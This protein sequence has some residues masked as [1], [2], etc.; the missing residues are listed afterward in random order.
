MTNFNLELDFYGNGNLNEIFHP[1]LPFSFFK[2][3]IYL[4]S[5]SNNANEWTFTA[6]VKALRP[7]FYM[8]YQGPNGSGTSYGLAYINAGTRDGD[9]FYNVTI[10]YRR[11]KIMTDPR[12]GYVTWNGQGKELVTNAYLVVGDMRG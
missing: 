7:F 10:T 9:G 5:S 2:E 1:K 3:L 4:G 12:N 8:T 6:R 11:I